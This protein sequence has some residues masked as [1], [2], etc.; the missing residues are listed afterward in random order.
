MLQSLKNSYEALKICFNKLSY[1]FNLRQS[2]AMEII[3]ENFIYN[4]EN[5]FL[6][7]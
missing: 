6:T 2:Y 1:N 7:I 4:P 3:K 5:M